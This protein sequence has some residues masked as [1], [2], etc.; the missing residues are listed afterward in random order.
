[1]NVQQEWLLKRIIDGE[2]IQ[3]TSLTASTL[4]CFMCHYRVSFHD[5][6]QLYMTI[7]IYL[8]DHIDVIMLCLALRNT[9]GCSLESASTKV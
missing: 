7:F 2:E 5:I 1:M 8:L 9:A 6:K 3:G 4:V